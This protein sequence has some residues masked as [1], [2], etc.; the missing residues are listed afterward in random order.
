MTT[1]YDRL[2]PEVAP[3]LKGLM[4]AIGGG[5]NLHDLAGTRAM[6]D[7]MVASVNA[8]AP[9][10]EGVVTEDRRVP[11][12]DGAPEVPVRIY[13][14][15]GRTEPLPALVWMH[16][17]GWVLGSLEM[18][19][20]AMREL[21]KDVGCVVVSVNYRLAPEHPFP[22]ALDDCYAAFKWVVSESGALRIDPARIAVGGASAGG[23]LAAGLAL[24][25]RDN[26]DPRPKL[27]VLLYAALDDR[28]VEPASETRPD[29]PFWSRDNFLVSWRSYL[30]DRF[31]TADVPA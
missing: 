5:F 29:N 24:R 23:N 10:L 20:L 4:D 30:G 15:T 11:G 21:A 8:E 16:P 27:Q 3:P 28:N 6:V 12:L 25:A 13:R 9:P 1:P 17:G 26:G 18:E 7:G 22:A 31:G 14:P 2:D 19:H